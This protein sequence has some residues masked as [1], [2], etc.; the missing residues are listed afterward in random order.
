MITVAI[1]DVHGMSALLDRLLREIDAFASKESFGPPQLVF[2]GDYVD[3]GP[4]SRSVMRRVQALW[5]DGAVCLRGNHEEMMANCERGLVE[6]TQFLANGGL[7]TLISY[8]GYEDELEA[9]RRWAST[10]PTSFEDELRVF[11]HAGLRPNLALAKQSDDDK[12]WI[13]GEFL[14][15]PGPFP[16]YVVHG[17][18]PV[19][20][21][22]REESS[23]DVR[24]SRCDIDTGACYGG[25][26]SAAFFNDGQAK[27]FHTIS[28]R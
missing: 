28:V 27:P 7:Q 21:P 16:K 25:T 15:H 9:D 26:L 14:G 13:R 2:L 3:R 4:D 1:G 18:T 22:R 6:K 10:L 17:H 12:M 11:V 19:L 24:E 5:S 20:A 8:A 23:P